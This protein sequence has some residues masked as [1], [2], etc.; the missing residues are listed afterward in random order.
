MVEGDV[1]AGHRALLSDG[2]S[3]TVRQLGA[4]DADAVL[5]LHRALRP[6]DHYLRF[7]GP[8][9][10]ASDDI[11]ARSILSGA[12]VGVGAFRTGRLVG[13]AYYVA[14]PTEADP[15][16][17]FAVDHAV[18]HRGVATLLLEHLA[19]IARLRGVRRLVADVLAVNHDMLRVFGD[20]GLPVVQHSDGEV[21]RVSLELAGDAEGYLDAV[22]QREGSADVRSLL[23]LLA[24]RSVVVIGAGRGRS[25]VGRAV[26]QRLVAGGFAGSVYAVNPHTA[27]VDGVPCHRSVSEL[28]EAVELAVLCV[29]AQAV[30]A[31]AAECGQHGVRALLVI[32]SGVSSDPT[33]AAGLWA[34]VE[35]YDMRLVG[36]NC[37]GVVNTDPAVRMDASFGVDALPGPI[38]VVTQS[39]GVAISLLADLERL[40]LGVSSMVS[41]GDSH[42]VSGD[43]LMLWWAQDDRTRAAV[44]YLESLR[45]PR[46]FARLARRL[47]RRMP[48][49]TVRSGS[50]VVGQRAAASHSASTA[51]PR[52]TRDALFRQAGV[53]AVDRMSE[54]TELLAVLSWQPL[55]AGRRVA[56]VSNASGAAV[57]A[58]DAAVRYGLAVPSLAPRTQDRLRRLL[59]A[60]AAVANPVDT[61]ATI[62]PASY[63][64]ALA[65][66]LADPGIDAV[67][68]VVAQTALGGPLAGIAPAV[69]ARDAVVPKPVLVVRLGQAAGIDRLGSLDRDHPVPSFADPAAAAA[70]LRHTV[71]RAEWLARPGTQTEE[72]LGVDADAAQELV[73]KFLADQPAG[74][75]LDPVQ[76]QALL[77]T[78][79]L[80]VGRL[81][82]VHEVAGA[83]A[84]RRTTV[85][86]VALKADVPGLLHK[87]HAD[88]VRT[89]LDTAAEV[90]HAFDE[91]TDRFGGQLRGV[92]VQPMA[93]PG[94]E[95]LLGVTGDPLF[96]PLLTF[97]LGGTSTDLVADRAHC[98]V[99]ATDADVD[100][101]LDSLRSSP[102]LFGPRVAE[103]AAVRDALVRLG[104]LAG[105]LP[106]IA[107]AELNPLIAGPDAAVAVD[108]RV[109][110]APA[111]RADPYLR[112]LPT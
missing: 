81:D 32:T 22:A 28:P 5:G 67:I 62:D 26:L 66:L 12:A 79:G 25:S 59:P 96:G 21:I 61:T 39:G 90:S 80:P 55:P 38:G 111:E 73:G 89:G 35:R 1:A 48:V 3:V 9:N 75:W 103:R 78:A 98:L 31:V 74:G 105:H 33:L 83:L 43:D 94:I 42:D 68:A 11:V 71:E 23:P 84:V 64:A 92:V 88:G 58:A 54:L 65:E 56:V 41:T 91:L 20:V 8:A 63:G 16:V 17:A 104:W 87:S 30:P 97:G 4:H 6:S 37:L 106:E 40:G 99:P 15:E 95:L 69:A 109:R 44:L 2:T 93:H 19:S 72:P 86:P 100:E 107:E 27:T 50:T 76:T 53:L 47:A 24:P 13:V 112:S 10:S 102:R 82:V 60:T 108:A 14:E 36:P 57:L 46:K 29:P 51:T 70:A 85:G 110:L 45:Q 18:Q 49:L 101:L 77:R 52:V 34:A 7:F